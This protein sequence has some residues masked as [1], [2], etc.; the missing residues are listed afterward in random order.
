METP[1][2]NEST[3]ITPT[4]LKLTGESYTKELGLEAENSF[5]CAASIKAPCYN[6]TD[7]APLVNILAH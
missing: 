5:Y 7:R 1:T 4:S 2:P 3:P 6:P